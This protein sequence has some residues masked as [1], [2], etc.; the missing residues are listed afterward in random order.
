MN[1]RDALSAVGFLL[2]GTVVGSA[3]FLE[4]CS[5]DSKKAAGIPFD[6]DIQ[7]LLNEIAETIL[8]TTPSSA[9]AKAADVA[10]FMNM[11][12]SECYDEEHQKI[13]LEGIGNLQD[14]AEKK[15]D[16]SFMNA[17]PEQ[18]TQFLTELD[19]EQKAY[20]KSKK[21]EDPTHYFR[22]VKELTILGY[23]SSEIGCTQA[24]RYVAVP[25]RYDGCVPYSK[26]ER[27]WATG[28]PAKYRP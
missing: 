24:L 19:E 2:G 16:I 12:V 21:K 15:F 8:P 18:R 25:G 13:F 10:G 6:Q 1:R 7:K 22:M 4:G 26:G 28:D 20:M 3:A 23:F 27:A 14:A 11:V 9:G 17:S 5:V